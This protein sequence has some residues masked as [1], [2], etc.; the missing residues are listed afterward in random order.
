MLKRLK[1]AL[2][3]SFVGAIA[4]GWVFAQGILHCA[5]ILSAP[6]AGWLVRREYRG[7]IERAN[8]PKGFSLQDALPELVRS[9]S[10]LL[11]GY[12]LLRWLYFTPLEQEAP[13]SS[14]EQSPDPDANSGV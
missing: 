9:L 8:Y 12:L 1:K 10:L 7:V 3:T 5:N 4:L 2:V 11:L 13:K 6:I 14:S